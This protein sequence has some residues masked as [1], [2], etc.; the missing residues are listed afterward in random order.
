MVCQPIKS[1]PAYTRHCTLLINAISVRFEAIPSVGLS[2]LHIQYVVGPLLYFFGSINILAQS[3]SVMAS[4]AKQKVFYQVGIRRR[5]LYNVDAAGCETRYCRYPLDQEGW[6]CLSTEVRNGSGP[7][8]VRHDQREEYCCVIQMVSHSCISCWPCS[9]SILPVLLFE[10]SS[11]H[12]YTIPSLGLFSKLLQPTWEA[13][14]HGPKC[15]WATKT[16]PMLP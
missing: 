3:G 15:Q 5:P 7:S 16:T 11:T 9:V 13:P 6:L 2:K 12:I 8:S 10:H 1:I 4:W 14:S